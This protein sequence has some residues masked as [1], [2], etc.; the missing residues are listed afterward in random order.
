MT[1]D[2][3]HN[4]AGLTLVEVLVATAIISIVSLLIVNLFLVFQSSDTRSAITLKME[5]TARQILLQIAERLREGKIDYD[6]YTSDPASEPEFLAIRDNEG[7]QTVFWFYAP[8]GQTNIY[9]CNDKPQD[10]TCN[11]AETSPGSGSSDWRQLNPGDDEFTVAHFSITPSSSPYATTDGTAP[12]SDDSPLI[13]V[14]MQ[15]H[16]S[17][18]KAE[19]ETD[20]I[21]TTLSPRYYDR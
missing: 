8:T 18:G 6:F 12:S 4:I 20:L 14:T 2:I 17:S 5:G 11:K 21:Q 10:E 9:V 1:G 7:I 15:L 19:V 16:Q 3:K 13:T